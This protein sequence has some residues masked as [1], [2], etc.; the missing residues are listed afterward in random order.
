VLFVYN[1]FIKNSLW[2]VLHQ[3][4]K[5][6]SCD[7]ITFQDKINKS[8]SK[9]KRHTKQ[10]SK[11]EDH[12]NILEGLL[13]KEQTIKHHMKK[14]INHFHS[15]TQILK[16]ERAIA[17][18]KATLTNM[19]SLKKNEKKMKISKF[20]INTSSHSFDMVEEQ[21]L[22]S[23]EMATK[24]F[25]NTM[26]TSPLAP[27]TKIEKNVG[28]SSLNF[29]DR[30][31]SFTNKLEIAEI[32]F[33]QAMEELEHGQTQ[34]LISKK[35]LEELHNKQLVDVELT[36]L[37][38]KQKQ[39]DV[40]LKAT[41]EVEK[42]K[43]VKEEASQLAIELATLKAMGK[44][45]KRWSS[46]Q[47]TIIIGDEQLEKDDY[48][49]EVLDQGVQIDIEIEIKSP[50][51]AEL[52]RKSKDDERRKLEDENKLKK[53]EEETR[54]LEEQCMQ[55]EAWKKKMLEEQ[56]MQE[57]AQKRKM[58]DDEDVRKLFHDMEDAKMKTFFEA[59][60]QKMAIELEVEK[61]VVEED[62]RKKDIE[63]EARQK[64]LFSSQ[65]Q[66]TIKDNI[67]EVLDALENIKD[68]VLSAKDESN[69]K[70]DTTF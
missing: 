12:F 27:L 43:K 36:T 40:E 13:E 20:P 31:Y 11:L 26:P 1:H 35:E 60:K 2:Q 23:V 46:E 14:R 29:I 18:L 51:K 6:S 58:L 50:T 52:V 53:N 70:V 17:K 54:I 56:H 68:V 30:K 63:E 28:E 41:H 22:K 19:Q 59:H 69:D 47:I 3:N 38:A 4:F 7:I 48:I 66:S 57:E 45:G 10:L 15:K 25:V 67:K 5:I 61:K 62:T 34:T 9:V 33:L 16:Q 42:V 44:D 65:T 24:Q 8:L 39:N 32:K 49:V 55:K 21:F 37:I 64:T